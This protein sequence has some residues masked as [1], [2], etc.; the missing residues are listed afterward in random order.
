M[1]IFQTKANRVVVSGTVDIEN[2]GDSGQI[3][4]ATGTNDTM[5]IHGDVVKVG[6]L[7]T[8]G[9][10]TIGQGTIGAD[11]M[12]QLYAPGSN[13]TVNFIAN[14]TLSGAGAKIIAGNTVNIFD[15]IVVTIGGSN[16]ASVYTNH[17]NYT[18]FGG[19]G[20]RTGTFGGAGA[21]NPQP[22]ANAPP[23]DPPARR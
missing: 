10:L 4:L 18:G 3:N 23:F 5:N 20:T 13:G 15:N 16:H 19:N 7:G 8:N 9:T 17:A 6:A 2:T 22:L 14:V 21:N 1:T 12:L 11:T